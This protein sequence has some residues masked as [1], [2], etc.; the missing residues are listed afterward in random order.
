MKPDYA[1]DKNKLSQLVDHYVPEKKNTAFY[2]QLCLQ[3]DPYSHI[4]QTLGP[5]QLNSTKIDDANTYNQNNSARN[6]TNINN[7][8]NTT[9]NNQ[10]NTTTLTVNS[11]ISTPEAITFYLHRAGHLDAISSIQILLENGLSYEDIRSVSINWG[12]FTIVKLNKDVLRLVYGPEAIMSLSQALGCNDKYLLLIR[13]DSDYFSLTVDFEAKCPRGFKVELLVTGIVDLNRC[14]IVTTKPKLKS[15]DQLTTL[16]ISKINELTT[17]INNSVMYAKPLNKVEPLRSDDFLDPD[18]SYFDRLLQY[19]RW[20]SPK[21][22]KFNLQARFEEHDVYVTNSSKFDLYTFM[23]TNPSDTKEVSFNPSY[24]FNKGD[25][26]KNKSIVYT[27]SIIMFLDYKSYTLKKVGYNNETFTH[28]LTLYSERYLLG[29][30]IYV[31]NLSAVFLDVDAVIKSIKLQVENIN[32]IL[33]RNLQTVVES[34]QAG[35]HVTNSKIRYINLV[36]GFLYDPKSIE[37]WNL[38]INAGNP[39]PQVRNTNISIS[40]ELHP[41]YIDSKDI[42][43]TIITPDI[44][45]R[46]HSDN[47]LQIMYVV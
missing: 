33:F 23:K 44:N 37:D 31:Q 42:K 17:S 43:I 6:N 24:K 9:T 45:L 4:I 1:E 38:Y 8:N 25:S 15:G 40:L 35:N 16:L 29:F 12:S 27:E 5:T 3:E 41:A 22:C 30:Y 2:M 19:H 21:C 26:K 10:N 7:Q 36:P 11:N 20:R 47:Y 39:V 14:N 28:E 46:R 32:I 34:E 13:G 18:T